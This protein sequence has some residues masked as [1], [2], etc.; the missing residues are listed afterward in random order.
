MRLRQH[1][2]IED[3][4]F[5]RHCGARVDSSTSPLCADTWAL[6]MPRAA[7]VGSDARLA[8]SGFEPGVMD[9]ALLWFARGTRPRCVLVLR[10]GGGLRAI[11]ASVLTRCFAPASRLT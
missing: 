5:S 7:L 9:Q 6:V 11:G 3:P 2:L 1:G 4:R 8:R 10:G